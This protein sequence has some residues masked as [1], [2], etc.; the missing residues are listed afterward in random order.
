MNFK[1]KKIALIVFL[2]T[3]TL[4]VLCLYYGYEALTYPIL[5]LG[6]S[7]EVLTTKK[8]LKTLSLILIIGTFGWVFQSLESYMGTLIIYK[9]QPFAPLWLLLLWSLFMSSTLRTM[10]FVFK[11]IYIT[12][13]F[14]CYA[15]PGT[16]FFISKLGLAELSEPLWKSL[17]LDSL[18]SAIVF[19]L[20]YLLINKVFYKEGSLYV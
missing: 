13:L 18:I 19:T 2:V 8:P 14:G 3:W 4:T 10:P 11:N 1:S 6:I 17:A 15:L 12:F 9:S 5:I 16:Y 7:Y 20:T